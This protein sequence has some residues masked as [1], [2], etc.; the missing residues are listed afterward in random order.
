MGKQIDRYRQSEQR[1]WES[2]GVKPRDRRVRLRTGEMVRVQETGDGPP[3]LLIHGAANAGTSWMSLMAKLPDFRCFA[4]DR[5]GC[6]LSDPIVDGPLR[7]IDAIE[8]YADRLLTDT[9]DA[10]E[11]PSAAV[12]ATS[13]GGY[14]AVRGAAA[15]PTR[16]D[17]IVEYSWLMGGRWTR[18]SCR[19][20]CRRY[21]G[22]G[23]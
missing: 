2:V 22:C 3:V 8:S 18:W 4:L 23:A 14:F 6:G 19:C 5:P 7:D 10:L 16:V 20:A 15:N 11:L 1:L 13:Y 17:R 21:R 12:L 9:L